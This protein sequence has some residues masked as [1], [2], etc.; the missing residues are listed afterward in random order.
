MTTHRN[1]SRARLWRTAADAAIAV[2]LAA[3]V[4]AGT[5]GAGGGQH[6]GAGAF[7]LIW[8]CAATL[9]VRR[10]WPEASLIGSMLVLWYYLALGYQEGP[11]YLL[12]AVAV[13]S[14]VM[15]RPLKHSLIFVGALLVA[16]PVFYEL[17]LHDRDRLLVNIA[18]T[19]IY[20][21]IPTVGGVIAREAR[22]ARA[23]AAAA[24]RERHRADER[25]AMARE[26][27]DVVGHS[28][29]VVSMNA[30]VALHMLEKRPEAA[31]GV[32]E[33][34]RAIRDTST[35]ALDDLR[36]TLAPLRDGQA[37]ELRPTRT[38]DDIPALVA[39]IGK[40][41]L[42]V[43]YR[44]TG[45]AAQVPGR[46]AA[47][48]YRVVQE[49]LTNV[50]RHAAASRATARLECGEASLTIEVTDDGRGGEVDPD[51]PGQGLAGMIERVEA[52]GGTFSAGPAPGGGFAVHAE[53]PYTGS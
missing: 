18:L 5:I 8:L 26:I 11:V 53:I 19:A 4:S 37:P 13:F 34:L 49:S 7:A 14:Y 29:A 15:A 17:I 9:S 45:D 36:S 28:L 30:G 46:V 16:F 44:Q 33:N 31:P 42:T 10:L 23:Q 48:A 38:L 52:Q 21:S 32:V 43:D 27:H 47:A 35:R 40:G 12:P 50:I 3:L 24:N 20:L 22:N 25:V 39:D 6:P 51:R 2:V 41:G 1:D